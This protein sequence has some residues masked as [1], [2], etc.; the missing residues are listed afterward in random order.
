MRRLESST[1][2]VLVL[3]IGAI[4]IIAG[5]AAWMEIRPIHPSAPSASLPVPYYPALDSTQAFNLSAAAVRNE[6]GGPWI[7]E[8]VMGVVSTAPFFP[9]GAVSA[10]CQNYPGPALWDMGGALVSP[11]SLMGTGYLP[12]WTMI[13]LNLTGA[14]LVVIISNATAH[15]VSVPTICLTGGRAPGQYY[16]N[17][18]SDISPG[19]FQYNTTLYAPFAWQN[20]N[21]DVPVVPPFDTNGSV[22]GIYIAGG[23]SS[24]YETLA[25]V[26][27]PGYDSTWAIQY[28]NCWASQV[29][30]GGGPEYSFQ[31]PPFNLTTNTSLAWDSGTCFLPQYTLQI[32]PDAPF[33]A[34]PNGWSIPLN[35]S[36]LGYTVP[37]GNEPGLVTWMMALHLLTRNTAEPVPLGNVSCIARPWESLACAPTGFGWYAVL[38]SPNGNWMDVYS[39][40]NGSGG[41]LYPNVAV[42]Q[43]DGLLIDGIPGAD[44]QGMDLNIT[45]TLPSQVSFQ[46]NGSI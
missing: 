19:A 38:T 40:H 20:V 16:V 1:R 8:S 5:W 42:M 39:N 26:F 37:S 46:W 18:R 36:G 34:T 14:D 23:S 28:T 11:V 10:Q 3:G 4:L 21:A 2:V 32:S 33:S 6:T 7:L 9:I 12:F 22:A 44:P 43:G 25:D 29:Q 17:N 41:W 30:M 24:Y 27:Y 15:V 35:I 45:S 13:Y 31:D